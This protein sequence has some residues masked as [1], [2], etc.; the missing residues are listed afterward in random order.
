MKEE[1]VMADFGTFLNEYIAKVKEIVTKPEDFFNKMPVS[2]GF[3]EPL[4]FILPAAV[5]YGIGGML[6]SFSLKS[7]IWGVIGVYLGVLIASAI[8]HIVAILFKGTGSFEA[9]FRVGAYSSVVYLVSWIPVLGGILALYGIVLWFFGVRKVHSLSTEK[10]IIVLIIP[11]AVIIVIGFS[12]VA[13][14]GLAF[15]TM[16]RG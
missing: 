11:I 16:G 9:T 4:M 13:M 14:F 2:G 8:I 1:V 5:V 7:L 10:T 12:L 6:F 15:L 3:N